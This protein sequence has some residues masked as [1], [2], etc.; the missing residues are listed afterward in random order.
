MPAAFPERIT[1]NLAPP[2][3][4]RKAPP[5]TCPALGL[6]AATGIIK[7]E[8]LTT[9]WSSVTALDGGLSPV[10][11]PPRPL[12]CRRARLPL[13]VPAAAA[14]AAAVMISPSS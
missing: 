3:S 14:E 4:A 10:A 8:R 1:V 2:T 9:S 12:L 7:P 5:S 11:A 6:L 13:L